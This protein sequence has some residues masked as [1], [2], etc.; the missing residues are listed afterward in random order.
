MRV[1]RIATNSWLPAV[2]C[3]MILMVTT[4]TTTLAQ[5]PVAIHPW[6]TE[7]D[8]YGCFMNY[9]CQFGVNASL[10]QKCPDNS[11]EQTTESY[12][13]NLEKETNNDTSTALV[14]RTFQDCR[15]WCVR[16][17]EDQPCSSSQP[18][19]EQ[20]YFCD[21]LAD[22]NNTGT[23]RP[24]PTDR[25]ECLTDPGISTDFGR[26]DCLL[27]DVRAC[28][29]L[30]F[31]QTAVDGQGMASR[32][33]QGSP[34]MQASG[35]LVDCTVLIHNSTSSSAS[36]SSSICEGATGAVCLVEDFTR[37]T[38]YVGVV[39]ACAASGGVAV[40]LY[41]DYSPETPNDEPWTGSL[42][43]KTT[44][45]P[46]VSISYND[47]V[48]LATKIQTTTTTTA[49]MA[50]VSVTSAGEVCQK[51][52]F[53]SETIPCIGSSAGQYCDFKWGGDEGFCRTCPEDEIGNPDPL[54]C[55]FTKRDKGRVFGQKGVESCARVC[56]SSLKFGNCKLC[57]QDINGFGFGIKKSS[58][59]NRCSFCPERDV[60]YP[61]QEFAMF[62]KGIQCWQVQKFFHSVRIPSD[63]PNCRLAQM[64]NYVCG[65]QGPGYGGASTD[66]K[67]NVLVWLPRVAAL[68]SFLVSVFSSS[69]FYTSLDE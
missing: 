45:I 27:C 16:G 7:C 38:Y 55:F 69:S 59:A 13:E 56:A 39:E 64:M 9:Y 54:G 58:K 12:C 1:V 60:K 2:W 40:V 34:S 26:E 51:R 62:G 46:S 17:R 32:A 19:Q 3:T 14:H 11:E 18:C 30:H 33:L 63:A 50:N 20:E 52:L 36:S 24:C 10:C 28:V 41:G 15:S 61:Q 29:P 57:P 35:P 6:M 68:L 48:R 66:T 43:F 42:S 49:E 22:N 65:C 31:S 53:C 21:F 5:E 47:G 44:P 67:R 23:C 4:T 25:H 37:N 8:E